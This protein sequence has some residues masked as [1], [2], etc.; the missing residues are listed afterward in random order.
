M[1]N[2]VEA[3][4]MA[5]SVMMFV[6]AL[7]LSV[8]SFSKANS[9]VTAITN[10]RDRE[11]QYTYI[12]PTGKNRIVGMETIIPTM[13]RAYIEHFEIRFYEELADGTIKELPI[14]YATDY[15]NLKYGEIQYDG[16]NKKTI[17]YVDLKEERF[18]TEINQSTGGTI[19][20]E[21]VA[22][23]HLDIILNKQPTDSKAPYYKQFYHKQGFYEKYKDEKFEEKLGEYYLATA[24]TEETAPTAD[25]NKTKKRVITYILQPK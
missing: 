5:F 11:T 12:E 25:S 4:K 15:Q 7:T 10:L 23:E 18:G 2:A 16:P 17:N 20:P 13:Y 6:L 24:E 21:Q 1:E 14:Y 8:S 3:L 22:I 9:A 19:P